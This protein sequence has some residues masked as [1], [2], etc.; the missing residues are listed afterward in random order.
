[1]KKDPSIP[2]QNRD[3]EAGSS[4]TDIAN[5]APTLVE[6]IWTGEVYGPYGWENTGVYVLEN[7]L[8][9]GGN[10]RHYSIGNYNVSG[11]SYSAEIAVH[12]YGPHR[13]IFGENDEHFEI[14][15]KGKLKDGVIEAR[16]ERPDKPKF[17]VE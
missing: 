2:T 7:G 5:P 14:R 17:D 16:V 11:D 6:G 8:I 4:A 10:S 15:V 1:M 13:T 9:L 12:Y 3:R